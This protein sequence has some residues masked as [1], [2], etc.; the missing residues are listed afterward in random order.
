VSY[1]S[2]RSFAAGIGYDAQR[3]EA[4]QV[5]LQSRQWIRLSKRLS[6]TWEQGSETLHSN[7][8]L[9]KEFKPIR[10]LPQR[11]KSLTGRILGIAN[12]FVS[13]TQKGSLFPVWDYL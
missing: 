8:A 2:K 5:S 1:K 13:A 11:L 7:T 12:I 6:A 4:L 3:A 10:S 9:V